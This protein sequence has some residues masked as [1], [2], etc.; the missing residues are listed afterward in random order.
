MTSGWVSTYP[1]AC[2]KLNMLYNWQGVNKRIRTMAP[3]NCNRSL[4]K[5]IPLTTHISRIQES[6]DIIILLGW[7]YNTGWAIY[8]YPSIAIT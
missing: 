4:V 7:H 5:N 2:T 3:R 1:R 6:D 8:M